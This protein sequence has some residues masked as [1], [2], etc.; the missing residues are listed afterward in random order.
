MAIKEPSVKERLATVER[1]IAREEDELRREKDPFSLIDQRPEDV[2]VQ[3][4]EEGD[5]RQALSRPEIRRVLY[6]VM[7]L[8]GLDDS[9]SDPNPTIMAH[10]AGRRSLALDLK[11]AIRKVDSGAFHQM[12]REHESNLKSREKKDAAS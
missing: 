1:M 2:L 11:R 10:H 9:D 3:E 5:L 8:G 12:E 4:G 6:R 7:M